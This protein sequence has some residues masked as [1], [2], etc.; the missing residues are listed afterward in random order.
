MFARAFEK[1]VFVAH[2]RL[3][4]VDGQLPTVWIEQHIRTRDFAVGALDGAID[5]DEAAMFGGFGGDGVEEVA[6]QRHG[7]SI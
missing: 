3:F 6:A 1:V 5:F 4:V 2:Q 7:D